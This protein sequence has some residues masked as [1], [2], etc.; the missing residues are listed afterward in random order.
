MANILRNL[1]S[2]FLNAF[3]LR[4]LCWFGQFFQDGFGLRSK[5]L[6]VSL[7]SD[8]PADMEIVSCMR[9]VGEQTINKSADS[10]FKGFL[11]ELLWKNWK[12]F[13]TSN[14]G[15]R[16]SVQTQ[17][18]HI[19]EKLKTRSSFGCFRKF[20]SQKFCSSAKLTNVLTILR[21]AFE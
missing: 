2:R 12:K 20:S 17:N 11:V 7:T 6:N 18:K 15:W 9:M 13:Q 19:E 14:S 8:M 16:A 10:H 1:A 21:V 5:G 4:F 3:Q